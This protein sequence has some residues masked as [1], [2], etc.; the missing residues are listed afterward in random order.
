MSINFEHLE[1]LFGR[2]PTFH[3]AHLMSI[4]VIGTTVE[5]EFYLYEKPVTGYPK[6]E[7]D[8]DLHVLATLVW[9]DVS[10]LNI[11]FED[12]TLDSVAF[13]QEGDRVVTMLHKWAPEAG[14]IISRSVQVAMCSLADAR[15]EGPD[16][17]DIHRFQ[18]QLRRP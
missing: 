11:H 3:D 8:E 6:Q 14:K 10:H 7:W 17:R 12:N 9:Q 16:A 5:G 1:H 2:V 13:S 4:T 15:F 18:L